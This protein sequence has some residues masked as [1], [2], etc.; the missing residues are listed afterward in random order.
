MSWHSRSCET[1]II[2][3]N[4]AEVTYFHE[5]SIL[6]RMTLRMNEK[7]ILRNVGNIKI[8]GQVHRDIK[9]IESLKKYVL[10]S[11]LYHAIVFN[12]YAV[13]NRI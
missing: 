12:N 10:L 9:R 11:C 4:D 13:C 5:Q 2:R 3:A 6:N 7:N 8:R 1:R